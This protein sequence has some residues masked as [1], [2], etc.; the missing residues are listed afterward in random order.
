MPL[1]PRCDGD[2]VA[3]EPPVRRIMPYLMRGRNEA[4]VYQETVYRKAFRDEGDEAT[5]KLRSAAAEPFRAWSARLSAL[6]DEAKETRRAVDREIGLITALPGP[7]ISLLVGLARSLALVQHALEDPERWLGPPEGDPAWRA[8]A[9]ETTGRAA[10]AGG[11][12]E[13]AAEPAGAGG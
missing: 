11:R 1:F 2:L 4:A 6:V 13:G 10:V 12:A 7:A 9:A 8:A 5:V 3:G